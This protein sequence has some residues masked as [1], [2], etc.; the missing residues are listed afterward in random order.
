MVNAVAQRKSR[1]RFTRLKG[2][3]NLMRE[4]RAVQLD[5]IV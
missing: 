2:V 4:E 5:F 1:A 3:E